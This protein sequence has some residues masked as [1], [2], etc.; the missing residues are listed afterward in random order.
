[1]RV[2]FIQTICMHR[3]FI[4]GSFWQRWCRREKLIYRSGAGMDFP[5]I[6]RIDLVRRRG[7]GLALAGVRRSKREKKEQGGCI[8][9]EGGLRPTLHRV[10]ALQLPKTY[11]WNRTTSRHCHAWFRCDIILLSDF[12]LTT[13]FS[14]CPLLHHQFL[15]FSCSLRRLHP[16]A[17]SKLPTPQL[18]HRPDDERTR[19]RPKNAMLSRKEGEVE[20]DG[21][22]SR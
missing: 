20:G 13:S 2:S 18:H 10:H 14:L 1:M 4:K 16:F 11:Q 17:I 15:C 22:D 21:R 8:R 5:F 19:Y 12:R 6:F 3:C 9:D 7:S